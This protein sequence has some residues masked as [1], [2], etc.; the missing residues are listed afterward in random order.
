MKKLVFMFM[1]IVFAV[2]S[3]QAQQ[4][5]NVNRIEASAD[6]GR[7]AIAGSVIFPL[8]PDVYATVK[9]APS[10][11]MVVVYVGEE[12]CVSTIAHK[13]SI[14]YSVEEV[15]SVGYTADDDARIFLVGGGEM[16]MPTEWLTIQPGQKIESWKVFGLTYNMWRSH[17]VSR[18]TAVTNEYQVS[19]PDETTASIVNATLH[20]VENALERA[21][22]NKPAEGE[23]SMN[24]LRYVTVN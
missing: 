7:Q 15:A 6:G 10:D 4:V 2:A 5:Y 3:S 11:Y 1:G 8:N 13:N 14:K 21:V 19:V 23:S 24:T 12:G 9:S 16:I 22:E 18:E 20:R 17:T